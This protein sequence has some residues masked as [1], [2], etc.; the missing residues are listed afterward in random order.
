MGSK[1][2]AMLSVQT[3]LERADCSVDNQRVLFALSYF[4]FHVA[5]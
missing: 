3:V 2:V 1:E 5:L 4:L